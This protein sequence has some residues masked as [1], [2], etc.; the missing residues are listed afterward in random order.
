MNKAF[1]TWTLKLD[2]ISN[3]G[4][5]KYFLSKFLKHMCVVEHFKYLKVTETVEAVPLCAYAV[6]AL[7]PGNTVYC[8]FY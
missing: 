1:E 8:I 6:E 2:P 5:I 3:S 7:P 4:K